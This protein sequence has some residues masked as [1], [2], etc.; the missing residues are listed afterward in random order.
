[1]TAPDC[2]DPLDIQEHTFR[3]FWETTNP[4]TGLEPDRYPSKSA[5][6]IAAVGFALIAYPIGVERGFIARSQAVQRVLTTLTFLSTR[7]QGPEP[8]GVAGH[9]GF[10]YHYL[11]TAIGLRAG[12]CEL[13]MVD[14]ALLLGGLRIVSRR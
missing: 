11:D 12:T 13:S 4:V 8:A 7:P 9:N 3:F 14:T 10:F 1:M 2:N 5:A 6:S